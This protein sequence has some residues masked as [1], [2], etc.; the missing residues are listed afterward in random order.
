MAKEKLFAK[1]RFDDGT[2]KGVNGKPVDYDIGEEY[3]GNQTMANKAKKAGL[4][5]NKGELEKK[6]VQNLDDKKRIE[7]LE[8]MLKDREEALKVAEATIV[9]LQAELAE[10]EEEEEE[11]DPEGAG[12]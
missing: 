3:A 7:E 2:K 8:R 6:A 11:D 9:D 5:C 4:I 12:E 1:V 10:Y